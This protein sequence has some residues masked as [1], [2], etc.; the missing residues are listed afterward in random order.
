MPTVS[1]IVPV[2]NSEKFINRCLF[3]LVNQTLEDIEIIVV[4]D[5]SKDNSKEK[6]QKFIEKTPY[7]IKYFEK[8]N[9]GLSSAR[10]LGMQHAKGEYI[11]FLDSDDYVELNMYEM[12]YEEAKTNSADLVECDFIWEYED[13]KKYDKRREYKSKNDMIKKPRVVA[14]NKLYKR[15]ILTKHNI[16]FPEG[17]I[18]EDLEFFLKLLPHVNRIAYLHKY[19]VHYTQ[20][21]G[22]L[23][24]KQGE[25]VGD[26]FKILSNIIDYYKEIGL[27]NKYKKELEYISMRICLGSSMKRILKIKDKKIRRK[28]IL[29]TIRF[30]R[31]K[32]A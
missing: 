12:M 30:L 11:A 19:F 28:M 25:Q 5:G 1:I 15:D 26:I 16:R 3:S 4:N 8:E 23:S 32:H 31:W 18:Y 22:S 29:K 24:N 13:F 27:Y 10:N 20:R 2:Y 21:E 6:I 14:W 17:L 9:G 7:K